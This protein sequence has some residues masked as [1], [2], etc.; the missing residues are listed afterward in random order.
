MN[1]SS[2]PRHVIEKFERRW[3]LRFFSQLVAWRSEVPVRSTAQEVVGP[4]GRLIPVAYKRPSPR[5]TA[6]ATV[7]RIP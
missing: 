2:F 7:H 3:A 4:A 1:E 6:K 5:N